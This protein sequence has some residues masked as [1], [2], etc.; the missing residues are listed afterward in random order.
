M[1]DRSDEP[2]KTQNSPVFSVS[3]WWTLNHSIEAGPHWKGGGHQW[4]NPPLTE[5]WMAGKKPT[6]YRTDFGN[7]TFGVD[8]TAFTPPE[9]ASRGQRFRL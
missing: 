2:E 8:D 7:I 6:Y 9:P 5:E 3:P 4:A 1:T